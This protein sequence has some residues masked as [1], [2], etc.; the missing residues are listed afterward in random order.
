MQISGMTVAGIPGIIIGR[1]PHHAWSMQVGHAHTVDYYIE[2]AGDVTGP[3]CET[4]HVAGA[5]DVVIP[6]FH[7]AHGPVVN[8]MPYNPADL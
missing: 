6:V 2:D 3:R 1:T 8:P 4:I 5:A 7:T